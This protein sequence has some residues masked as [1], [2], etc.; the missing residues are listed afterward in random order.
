MLEKWFIS[1]CTIYTKINRQEEE[2]RKREQAG[3]RE[4]DPRSMGMISLHGGRERNGKK[5]DITG[6]VR[7][8]GATTTSQSE[9]I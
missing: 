3:R 4:R 2:E 6:Q 9:H 7:S 8:G 1:G 5:R